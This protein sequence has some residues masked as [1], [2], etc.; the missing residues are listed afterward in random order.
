MFR[1]PHLLKA[2]QGMQ[3]SDGEGNREEENRE[4]KEAFW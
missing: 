4:E 2:N 1:V 3:E